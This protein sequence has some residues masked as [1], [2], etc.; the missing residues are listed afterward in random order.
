MCW[1]WRMTLLVSLLALWWGE[2]AAQPTGVG[3]GMMGGTASGVQQQL[4]D[5]VHRNLGCASCHGMEHAMTSRAAGRC[6]GCHPQAAADFTHGP[7]G[8]ALR[9]GEPGGALVISTK[10]E[11]V[12]GRRVSTQREE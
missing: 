6:Q 7:H 5:S 10:S 8:I 4:A 12:L 9:R 1:G 2:A 3:P 11:Q